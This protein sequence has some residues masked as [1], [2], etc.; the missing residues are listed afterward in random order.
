MGKYASLEQRKE[1]RV[2]LKRIP[3][4]HL[5]ANAAIPM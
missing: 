2:K 3:T 5:A 4:N 1:L